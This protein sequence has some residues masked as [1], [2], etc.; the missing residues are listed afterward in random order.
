LPRKLAK[1]VQIEFPVTIQVGISYH[2]F[3]KTK[4]V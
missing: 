1:F 4:A 3:D 2:E